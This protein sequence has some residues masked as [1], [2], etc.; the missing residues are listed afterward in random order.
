EIP[1]SNKWEP[2]AKFNSKDRLVDE[3]GNKVSSDYQGRQYRIIEKRERTFSS[4]ERFERGAVGILAV[5]CTLFFALL[6]K[7]VRDLL[8]SSKE[9]VR[10][11]VLVP[12]IDS[13]SLHSD[14]SEETIELESTVQA[15]PWECGEEPATLPE[16]WEKH[17]AI[18]NI[19]ADYLGVQVKIPRGN[20]Y[21]TYN[22]K[23]AIGWHGSYN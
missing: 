16:N 6:S 13:S 4:F 17:Q 10:F 14:P 9:S 12:R 5:I 19:V 21:F 1:L 23:V 11:A 20:T 2:A 18:Q 15:A 22:G 3:K 7:W 8:T